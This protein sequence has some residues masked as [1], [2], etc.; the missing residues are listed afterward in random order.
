MGGAVTIL[1]MAGRDSPGVEG[2]IL[3]TP[4]VW[5]RSTMPFYQRFFLSLAAQ[6]IPWK[7]V[8]GE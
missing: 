8:T 4:A 1:A 5:T 2:L 6:T 3:V 7:K